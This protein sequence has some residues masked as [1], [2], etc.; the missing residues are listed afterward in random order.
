[1]LLVG[2]NNEY[3]INTNNVIGSGS[4]GKVFEC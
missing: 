4:Y 2:K 3:E 1:M